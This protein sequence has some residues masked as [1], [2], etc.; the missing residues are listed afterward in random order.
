M[1]RCHGAGGNSCFSNLLFK[2]LFG[3]VL[4]MVERLLCGLTSGVLRVLYPTSFHHETLLELVSTMLPRDGMGK[5][6]L[7]HNVWDSIRLRDNPISWCDLVWFYAR[8]LRH[9]FNM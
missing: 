9:A 2:N 8:I 5:P 4:V 6:F 1:V 7:V 3:P